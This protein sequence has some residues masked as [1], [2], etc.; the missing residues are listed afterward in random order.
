MVAWRFGGLQGANE[1]DGEY[2][3]LKE[4]RS[5][6]SDHAKEKVRGD[7]AGGGSGGRARGKLSGGPGPL[8]DDADAVPPTDWRS[9]MMLFRVGFYLLMAYVSSTRRSPA[10]A[11]WGPI[12]L[13]RV[14]KQRG[15]GRKHP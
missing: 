3:K 10:A 6:S 14:G 4:G 5:S 15:R 13:S 9:P 7:A 2:T 1:P 12:L 11:P 8:G